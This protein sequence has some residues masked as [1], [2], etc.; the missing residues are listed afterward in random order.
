MRR[1]IFLRKL[2][3]QERQTCNELFSSGGYCPGKANINDNVFL[4]FGLGSSKR[5]E[6]S[7]ITL[8]KTFALRDNNTNGAPIV[9]TNSWPEGGKVFDTASGTTDEYERE[10]ENVSHTPRKSTFF[11]FQSI[12]LVIKSNTQLNGFLYP[13]KSSKQPQTHSE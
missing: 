6:T 5:N 11:A 13:Q 7:S 12:S 2:L 9:D 4:R 10:K 3:Q 1:I 8:D